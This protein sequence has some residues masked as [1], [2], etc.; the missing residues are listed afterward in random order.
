MCGEIEPITDRLLFACFVTE[1]QPMTP[2]EIAVEKEY[3]AQE[4][5]GILC[6]TKPPTDEQKHLAKLEANKW[7]V[8]FR[9]ALSKRRAQAKT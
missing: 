4:R 2:D 7:E 8:E 6:G 1:A 3:R 9:Q 5:L